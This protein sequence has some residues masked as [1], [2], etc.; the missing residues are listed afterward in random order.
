MI[1]LLCNYCIE[2]APPKPAVPTEEEA[3]Q[4]RR[5]TFEACL[6]GIDWQHPS[7]DEDDRVHNWRNYAP[8]ELRE[9]W[10]S[11]SDEQKKAIAFALDECASNEH[12]D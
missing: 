8:F 3:R 5:E 7:W 11:F 4:Q 9:M 12:W 1:K 10:E 6:I 2:R